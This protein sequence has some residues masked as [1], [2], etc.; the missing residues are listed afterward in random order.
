MEELIQKINSKLTADKKILCRDAMEIA[1]ELDISPAIVGR[2]LDKMKI[3][4]KGC[5]LGC[6]K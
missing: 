2:E 1:R 6:F 3:K 5:Q 4:I